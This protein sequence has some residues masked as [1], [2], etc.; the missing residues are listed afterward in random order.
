MFGGF[1]QNFGTLVDERARHVARRPF[2]CTI[3]RGARQLYQPHAVF[4][5]GRSHQAPYEDEPDG[6][7]SVEQTGDSANPA[8]VI[9]LPPVAR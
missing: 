7:S 2:P 1:G 3:S 8:E 6:G 4:S 5:L 9:T